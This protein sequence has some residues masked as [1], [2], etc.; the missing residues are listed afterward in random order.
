MKGI[1]F[2]GK[3]ISLRNDLPTPVPARDEVLVKVH[4]AGICRTDLEITEGYMDFTG[5]MGHEFVGS[6]AE[7]PKPWLK[8]RV[9]AEINNPCG[10]CE[11]CKAGL[12]NHCPH[13]T[14]MGIAGRDGCFA[15]Y[16]TV[17]A[18]NL[19]AVPDGVP[20]ESAVFTE[21]LAAALQI[22]EQID[23]HEHCPEGEALVLGDG[24]LGLLAAMV[25]RIELHNVLLVG[26][27]ENKLQ[28]AAGSEV[29]TQTVEAYQPEKKFPLVVEATGSP[30]GFV[31]AMQSVRPR[32]TIVLKSTFAAESGMNLA[33][34]VVDEVTVIGSRCGP[35]DKAL[36][37]L[38]VGRIEPARLISKRFSLEDG[39]AALEAAKD[40]SNV[41]VI[42]D[43]HRS[44]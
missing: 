21:P 11:Y 22:P 43:A 34:V 9:V 4:L 32:G 25:M 31:L 10:Q 5:V 20:D 37:T 19:H 41:K 23:L 2:D 28:L 16:L 24:R 6:V 1:V 30:E 33:P 39:P 42:L 14:V 36:K 35:F 40:S 3:N 8:K 15:E 17:P 38:F 12:G 44:K 18:G 26:K 13:R 27:H 29:R 7:G